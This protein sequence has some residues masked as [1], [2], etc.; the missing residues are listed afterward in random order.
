MFISEVSG[1]DIC[2]SPQ[3]Q[4]AELPRIDANT[5]NWNNLLNSMKGCGRIFKHSA[6]ELVNLLFCVVNNI[7]DS[8]CDPDRVLNGCVDVFVFVLGRYKACLDI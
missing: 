3:V 2:P 8:R 4:D 7:F 5:L 6:V 1:I